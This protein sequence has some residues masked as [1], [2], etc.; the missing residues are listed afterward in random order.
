M[1]GAGGPEWGAQNP[2]RCPGGPQIPQS[3]FPS[4]HGTPMLA[5]Q[6]LTTTSL[7]PGPCSPWGPAH[8]LPHPPHSCRLG[9]RR[10]PPA[11]TE[12]YKARSVGPGLC[13]L[14]PG[15]EGE[16]RLAL[17][18]AS[19]SPPLEQRMRGHGGLGGLRDAGSTPSH[20]VPDRASGGAVEKENDLASYEGHG[21]TGTAERQTQMRTGTRPCQGEPAAAGRELQCSP[22]PSPKIPL[23]PQGP[24]LA[25]GVGPPSQLCGVGAPPPR[26]CHPQCHFIHASYL[27]GTTRNHLGQ[28]FSLPLAGV[29]PVFPRPPTRTT[30]PCSARGLSHSSGV[31]RR[32]VLSPLPPAGT[33]PGPVASS[34]RRG[35]RSQPAHRR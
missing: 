29:L 19:A 1:P 9:L 2:L 7:D 18:S 8:F 27:R 4:S 31:P 24:R 3:S 28:L 35:N 11:G 10:G 15:P 14:R 33:P 13:S 25:A 17:L 32:G 6:L 26:P 20:Q 16:G 23:A 34:L 22:A 12:W 5:T 21:R 30:A